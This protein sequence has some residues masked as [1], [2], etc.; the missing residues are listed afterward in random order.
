MNIKFKPTT[1]VEKIKA[2][3]MPPGHYPASMKNWHEMP[4]PFVNLFCSDLVLA[5]FEQGNE[6]LFA[7]Q[8]A[9]VLI[10]LKLAIDSKQLVKS[11]GTFTAQI[12]QPAGGPKEVT[13]AAHIHGTWAL[14]TCLVLVMP[15]ESIHE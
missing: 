13:I 3:K 8:V 2:G 4:C 15:G 5:L 12:S 10:A 6:T 11:P 7:T 1:Y 9:D 14:R